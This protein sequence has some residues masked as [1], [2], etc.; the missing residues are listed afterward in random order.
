MRA[1]QVD[2]VDLPLLAPFTWYRQASKATHYLWRRDRDG[3]KVY[4]HRAI[5]NA[6]RSERIDHINGDG[7]DNRRENLRKCTNAQNMYNM[8]RGRGRSQYKGVAWFKRD[9]CWRAYICQNYKQRHLG[10]FTTEWE[11]AE[12]YNAAARA[13]FGRFA[14]LN[15][16][17][18]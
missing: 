9:S 15:T 14:R 8:R 17:I 2:A 12:A 3:R 13:L 18:T 1:I 16:V 10:Y 7:L 5:M 11:A 6:R 4:L